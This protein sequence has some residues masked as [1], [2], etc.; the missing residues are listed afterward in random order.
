MTNKYWTPIVGIFLS[1]TVSTV[2]LLRENSSP[3]ALAVH[4]LAWALLLPAVY[5][6]IRK[7]RRG[8]AKALDKYD[9]GVI[10]FGLG[11]II[12]G[13]LGAPWFVWGVLLAAALGSAVAALTVD[14]QYA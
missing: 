5:R 13:V 9:T 4:G 6:E 14:R 3:T 8:E 7:A 10:G 2:L 11:G 1:F 12:L